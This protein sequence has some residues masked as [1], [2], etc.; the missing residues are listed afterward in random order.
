MATDP[1]QANADAPQGDDAL[2]SSNYEV[3]RRRLTEQARQLAQRADSLNARRQAF[4][5]S[6]AM[7]VIGNDTL[8]T[9]HNCIPQDII[10][11]G[12]RLLFGYNVQIKL[13]SRTAVPDV[14][15]LHKFEKDG[16][17]I[18]LRHV[19]QDVADNFL[20]DPKFNKDFDDLYAYFKDAFLRQLR[21][22]EGRLLAIFQT[23]TSLDDIRVLRWQVDATHQVSYL[24]NSGVRDNKRQPTHDFEWIPTKRED[25]VTGRH[26]HISILDEVFVEAVGG[27][28]TIK[29]EDSTEDGEGIYSE[30]VE[31]R[32]QS[33]GD[34]DI[35]YAKLGKLIL[36]RIKPYREQKLRYFVF[37]TL[38]G[39]VA[40]LDAIGQSC[41]QLPEEHGIIFPG[42]YVLESGEQKRFDQDTTGMR[43]EQAIRSPNGEDVLY[44]FYRDEDGQYLLLS[45]NLIR[46]EVQNPLPCHGYSIFDDGTMILFRFMGDQPTRVHPMQIWSSP[47]ASAEHAAQAPSDGS[48]MSRVGNAELVRGISDAYTVRKL[49]NHPQPTSELYGQIIT[50]AERMMDAYYWLGEAE[51]E[52]MAALL[53][54]VVATATLVI[55]E[56]SKV[57]AMRAQAQQALADVERDQGTLLAEV[58]NARWAEI[59]RYVDGLDALRKQRGRVI[60]LR[61]MKYI[62]LGRLSELEAALVEHSDRL[63][64]QTVAFLQGDSALKSYRDAVES[65]IAGVEQVKTTVEATALR[66]R[67]DRVGEGLGLL[68]EMI[69]GLKIEDPQARTH[70]LE[71]LGEVL[72]QQNR[73]RAMLEAR[74]MALLEQEGK[75]EFAVQFQLIGQAVTSALGMCDT[76]DKCD[77]QLTRQM[78]QLEEM[79]ARFSEFDA[80][81]SRLSEKREEIYEAFEARKQQLIEDR[82]RKASGAVEAAERIMQGVMRRVQKLEDVEA[83]N[84]YFAADPMV[85]KVRELADRLRELA[86]PVKADDLEA[87][88]KATRDQSIR[89]LRDRLDLFEGGGGDAVIRFGRHRFSVNTQ[90]LELTM[91]PRDGTMRLH[92]T[93]SDFYEPITDQAFLATEHLWGQHLASETAQV[94]RGEHLAAS[95]LFDAE[96]RDSA[97]TMEAL[98]QQLTSDDTALKLIRATIESRY[99]EGYERGVHDHDALLILRTILGLYTT[100]GLLRFSP[101]ARA[102]ATLYWASPPDALGALDAASAAPSGSLLTSTSRRGKPVACPGARKRALFA[103]RAQ[104]L[105][106]LRVAFDD[107]GPLRELV[108]DLV[109]ALGAFTKA[110]ALPHTPRE[111]R[112]AAGYLVEELLKDR[113]TFVVS[114]EAQ[115]LMERFLMS[116]DVAGTK[117]AFEEDLQTIDGELGDGWGLMMGWLGG[118]LRRRREPIPGA[119]DALPEAA[120]LLL[121]QGKLEREVSSSR[122]SAKVEGLL[123]QH[124]RIQ[125]QAMTLRL[126]SFLARLRDHSERR[127]PEWRAYR[128]LTTQMLNRERRKLRL[129]ELRPQVLSTFVRNRLIDEVYLPIIGDNLAKQMGTVGDTGRSDRSGLLLLISPPGYGKTTL[130]EY[131]ASRMGLTFMKVN[132]PAL[133]HNVTSIDPSEAPNATARQEVEKINLALRM[134]NNVMLYL[135]DIQHTHPE[136]L[137]KFI[138]LCDAT[139][140]IEG[141]WDGE[142]KTYDLRGKRFSVVMAG[143]PY[144]ETGERFQ[145]PDMLANRADTYNLGDIVGGSDDAF[146]LSYI[147][148]ALTANPV[149]APLANRDRK[150][151]HLFI[152]M[153]R[154][155]QLPLSELTHAYSAVEAAEI[156]N[157]LQKLFKCQEVLLKV[158]LAYITSAAQRDDYRTE[159]PFKLQGSYR[160]MTKLAEKVASAMNEQELQALIDD[161]YQGEAQTLTTES[162]QSLLKLAELRGRMSDEQRARWEEIKREFGR[163]KMM[164][165]GDDDPVTRMVGPLTGLVEGVDAMRAALGGNSQVA[166]KLDAL[167]ASLERASA[168]ASEGRT[169]A[170]LDPAILTQLTEAMSRMSAP[171]AAPP[172]T[173]QVD[174]S[175][176]Q[177]LV[178]R[179]GRLVEGTLQQLIKVVEGYAASASS[180]AQVGGQL[181]MIERW[182]EHGGPV[183]QGPPPGG[184]TTQAPLAQP[185]GAPSFAPQASQGYAPQ[186]YASRPMPVVSAE[187]TLPGAGA[188]RQVM[189]SGSS[190]V[191]R[192]APQA[193]AAP[194]AP[195]RSVDV[196]P[197]LELRTSVSPKPSGDGEARAQ[198]FKQARKSLGHVQPLS[199]A[200]QVYEGE[201]EGAKT[202]KLHAPFK[203]EGE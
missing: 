61:E 169:S 155:E 87:R 80:F 196:S 89:A 175:G 56:F 3:I 49:I 130:M 103:R 8:R 136:L 105:G 97:L 116:L 83:L 203:T 149:L 143:N 36:L 194:V 171:Q 129:D 15:S 28:L 102:L 63:S 113:P 32:N 127:I 135:D 31:D 119:L 144:T 57:R 75:A 118:F 92:I 101:S 74:R 111:V 66:E 152:R 112:D 145:I 100:A 65:A 183:L 12:D 93:G 122:A 5:G 184:P 160:N 189:V 13:K 104:S 35:A 86:D 34:A 188:P 96:R 108:E 187:Q 99:D 72:G 168:Q 177:A 191:T 107:D 162:E 88:L 42:G 30:P 140:R 98:Q 110:Q 23:G 138:S 156:V 192:P 6:T 185:A 201:Q 200:A 67:I 51:L 17:T 154:G 22:V 165:G 106:R 142:S 147:E 146:A 37:N 64:K 85:M 134:G 182:M 46:K 7:Q 47:F 190:V 73:A 178:E 128:E 91:V 41:L 19:A 120:A 59:D 53:K 186:G 163:R 82:Q 137:Q 141:V 20:S 150:D 9:E 181:R 60:T 159:P 195:Q 70:I 1:T 24:D 174:T 78:V 161:H 90:P 39:T 109:E 38:T 202:I 133:G 170:A 11:L 10:N 179:Q 54:E 197:E 121:T 193:Q 157:V 68:T 14:F 29:V 77:E 199:D 132:G 166:D 58:R 148:N 43:I 131:I 123:G 84:A 18:A 124:P 26:P 2:D 27:D 52:D 94:Y 55:D 45:Y 115:D 4:F 44:V 69:S 79:E 40:R 114:A 76:P 158:N 125:Q 117:L 25:H 16:D 50:S 176:M 172:A 151:V 167:R 62:D 198:S 153:A 139:R 21:R 126:D 180:G 33:L 164:G 71:S 95:I 173:A 81:L 48:L